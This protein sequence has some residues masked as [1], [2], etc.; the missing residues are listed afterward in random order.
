MSRKK[1]VDAAASGPSQRML[2]VGEMIRHKIADMLSRSEIHDDVLARH[3]ITVPEVRM[4][5][6][7]RL[8]TVYVLPLGGKQV[9]EVVAALERNKKFIRGEVA[10]SVNLKFA[11]DLRFRRDESFDEGFRIERLLDSERVKRDTQKS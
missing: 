7:M 4:S 3:V 6:D 9:D 11:T 5:P 8:A 10:R 1:H 2:R